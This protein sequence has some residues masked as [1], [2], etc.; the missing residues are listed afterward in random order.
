MSGI[1]QPVTQVRLTNVAVVRYKTKGHRYEIACYKNKVVSWRQGV[2]QDIDEVLQSRH[3]FANVSKGVLAGDELLLADFGTRDEQHIAKVILE[4]GEIQVSEKERAAALESLFRDISVLVADMCLNPQTRRPYPVRMIEQGMRDAH[5][6]I[7]QHKS[8]KSQALTVIKLLQQNGMPLDRAH[9]R[10]VITCETAVGKEM[11]R[12]LEPLI[13]KIEEEDWGSV[14]YRVQ[15]L[16]SPGN[17]RQVE[18]I[19]AQHNKGR[20]HLQ[21]VDVKV[22]EEAIGEEDNDE[23]G[24]G[25]SEG[26]NDDGHPQPL[27]VI[28]QPAPRPTSTAAITNKLAATHI[29][30]P[31]PQAQTTAGKSK[32]AMR[33]VLDEEEIRTVGERR[34]WEEEEGDVETSSEVRQKQ[35]Q[36]ARK[37]KKERKN[38]T[39]KK[40][41][42]DDD[43]DDDGGGKSK[44]K[45]KKAAGHDDDSEEADEEVDGAGKAGKK[46]EA[47]IAEA[48]GEDD[49]E[50][51]GTARHKKEKKSR[52]KKKEKAT[53]VGSV[54]SLQSHSND[55]DD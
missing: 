24:D 45:G 55:D 19:I 39:T 23:E 43:D 20:A 12:R 4:K 41:K 6:S 52:R 30:Q 15:V 46:G 36:A 22:Q 2:E 31:Q 33:K 47:A 5:Y 21:I 26:D 44:A 54:T 48:D 50:E 14:E 8:A 28:H 16:L 38:K 13:E 18:E 49:D 7:K 35:Q 3:I 29:T 42:D 1:K 11:K 17:Y 40:T 51:N 37:A 10:V 34:D 32:K 53:V 9:M 27:P 25:H